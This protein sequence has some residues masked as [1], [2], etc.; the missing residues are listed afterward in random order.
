MSEVMQQAIHRSLQLLLST[1][2][3]VVTIYD[4]KIT[5]FYLFDERTPTLTL[6][7]PK[8]HEI[9]TLHFHQQPQALDERL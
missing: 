6:M 5:I 9:K 3:I 4:S 8:N 1:I 2:S 7:K